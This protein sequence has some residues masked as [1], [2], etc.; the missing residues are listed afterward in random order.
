MEDTTSIADFMH[1]VALKIRKQPK[2]VAKYVTILEDNWIEN[3]EGIKRVDD[4]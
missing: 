3:V 2:D 4:E 1:H